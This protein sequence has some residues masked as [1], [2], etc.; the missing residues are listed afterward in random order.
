MKSPFQSAPSKAR[1]RRAAGRASRAENCSSELLEKALIL[2]YAAQNTSTPVWARTTIYGALAY[3]ISPIDAIPDFVPVV[4]FSDDL[5]AMAAAIAVV[6]A[7]ITPE[8]IRRAKQKM[9]EL[10]GND[11]PRETVFRNAA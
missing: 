10:F 9:A 11:E 5:A 2:Y 3:L 1:R 7:Y 6:T 8:V 4:G